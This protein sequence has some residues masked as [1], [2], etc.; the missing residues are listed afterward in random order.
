MKAITRRHNNIQDLVTDGIKSLPCKEIRIGKTI[1]FQ[2]LS[3][4]VIPQEL[5]QLK[6]DIFVINK[7]AK[8]IDIVDITIPFENSSDA[9]ENARQK[10]LDKYNPLATPLPP[11]T[12]RVNALVIGSVGSWLG[13]N[14]QVLKTLGLT[15]AYSNT[16]ARL[17]CST[18]I[19]WS[20]DIYV[21]HVSGRQQYQ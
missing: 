8:T 11:W 14:Y 4:Q 10:K 1:P 21:E 7:A 19:K 18:S 20:R 3:S 13:S 17:A 15:N 16:L 12:V 9:L 2:Q 5:Q 6:P